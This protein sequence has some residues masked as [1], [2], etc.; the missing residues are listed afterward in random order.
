MQVG[1]PHVRDVLGGSQFV[2]WGNESVHVLVTQEAEH[3][4]VRTSGHREL[5][6]GVTVVLRAFL[7]LLRGESELE[8]GFQTGRDLWRLFETIPDRSRLGGN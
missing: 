5:Q 1:Q 4:Q 8:M 2:N 6:L 7:F 3:V